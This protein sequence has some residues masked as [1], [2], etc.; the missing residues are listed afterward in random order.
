MS[1]T[2]QHPLGV[3]GP[4]KWCLNEALL[5][6]PGHCIMLDKALKEYFVDNNNHSVTPAT[7]WA[8]HKAVMR[9]KLIQIS[10]QL[11][12]ERKVEIQKLT[13]EFLSISK[14]HK[15]NPTTDTLAQLESAQTHPNLLQQRTNFLD[16]QEQNFICKK[17]D[18]VLN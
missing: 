3:K 2:L 1:L 18:L 12:R 16:G 14:R 6:N 5:S 11:K 10:S 9:G 4:F 7:L 13:G 17:T 15:H 8:A